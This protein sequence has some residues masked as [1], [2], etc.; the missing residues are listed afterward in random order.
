MTNILR[1]LR[2][3]LTV[4]AVMLAFGA[5]AQTKSAINV[6]IM[7]PLHNS[8]GDGRRAIEYYRGMLLA[9]EKLKAEGKNVTIRAWNVP[10]KGD[11]RTTLLK[12]GAT[13][14][15][16]IFGPMYSKYVKVMGDFCKAY[17]IK[18]V[19][20]FS[21]VGNDVDKNPQ[22]YQVYQ[23]PDELHAATIQHLI[24]SF[25]NHHPVFIDCNDST[26]HMGPFTSAARSMMEKNG[27]QYNI[28]N[29][30]TPDDM[31]AKAFSLNTP[32]LVILNTARSSEMIQATT[33]LETLQQ[34]NKDVQIK[35]FGYTEWLLYMKY[36]KE[37]FAKFDTYIPTYYFYNEASSATREVERRYREVFHTSMSPR[38]P[39]FALMGYDHA[40]YFIG[41]HDKWLQT[42][43]NFKKQ[44]SGGHR[45]K[46]FMF[47]H[48]KNNGGIEAINF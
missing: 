19:I 25:P 42:P 18:M 12:D 46:A 30:K 1:N 40:M 22:I 47:I 28:T 24:E 4:L 48:F 15:N 3:T 37:R 44:G 29:L 9:V 32:N 38:I 20:P 33:K 17:G 16:I 6:G 8:D 41:G 21:V 31:F 39:H 14:C 2:Y 23:S 7:L 45:N 10:N 36:N 11:V 5:S 13:D 35:L 34:S 26:S 43:L 27:I